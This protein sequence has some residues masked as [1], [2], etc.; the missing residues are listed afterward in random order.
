MEKTNLSFAFWLLLYIIL[1]R[2]SSFFQI[3]N[4]MIIVNSSF[5]RGFVAPNAACH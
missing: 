5:T 4:L 1:E 2:D 3:H